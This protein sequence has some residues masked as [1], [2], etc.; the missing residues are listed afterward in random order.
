MAMKPMQLFHILV[1]TKIHENLPPAEFVKP[2]GIVEVAICRATGLKASGSCTG[3]YTEVFTEDTVPEVCD[4]HTMAMVCRETNLLCCEGCPFGEYRFYNGVP[5]KERDATA[6]KST[7]VTTGAAPTGVCPHTASPLEVPV[8]ATPVVEQ[9][10]PTEPTPPQTPPQ[11]TPE[12]PTQT[13]TPAQNTTQEQPE[14]NPPATNTTP[15]TPPQTEPPVTNTETNPP[16]ESP[17]DSVEPPANTET[18]Q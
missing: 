13:N 7:A 10:P 12:P 14:Q 15:V 8:P 17:A 6:W 2:E 5:P 16:Q 18:N 11:T 1:M 4:G 3:V 9:T